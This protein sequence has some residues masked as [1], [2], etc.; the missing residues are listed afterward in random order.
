MEE[1]II[2][3]AGLPMLSVPAGGLHGVGLMK[4][5]RG[6][7]EQIRGYRVA[8]RY[9]KEQRP[10]AVFTTGGYLAGP[11]TLAAR[12]QRVPILLYV[13]DVEP[14]QS[15]VFVARYAR[16][17]GVTV[18]D[19]RAFLPAEKVVVTGYPLRKDLMRW[20]RAEGRAALNLDPRMPVLLVYGGSR[21]ARSLN[22]A[23][24][25][26]LTALLELT[27]IVHLSGELDWPE[28]AA[29]L[30]ALTPAQQARYHAFAYLHEEMGAALA[31][32]DLVVAR[33]GASI[34]GEVPYFGLPALLVPYPYAWRYQK[35]NAQ[36]L[37]SRGAAQLVRDEDLAEELL[38]RVEMLLRDEQQRARMAEAARTLAQP[39]AAHTLA[40]MLVQIGRG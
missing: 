14:A 26:N 4:A 16:R 34:L 27:Q 39:Q 25:K 28:V 30:E 38:P 36:W 6:L 19:S 13:P 32:A 7:R 35:V 9:L 5:I 3:R 22:R 23:L 29:A 37:E 21:G 2:P 18:E 33:A 1:T 8:L 24:Q 31:A 20:T 12:A 10:S 40:Q 17:I 15:V 11:V